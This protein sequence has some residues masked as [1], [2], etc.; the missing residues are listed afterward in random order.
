MDEKECREVCSTVI[1]SHC[2]GEKRSSECQSLRIGDTIIQKEEIGFK[3]SLSSAIESLQYLRIMTPAELAINARSLM[4][5][6]LDAK[7]KASEIYSID[8]LIFGNLDL[9]PDGIVFLNEGNLNMENLRFDVDRV[10]VRILRYLEISEGFDVQSQISGKKISISIIDETE[11]SFKSL[12]METDIS[13]FINIYIPHLFA[14]KLKTTYEDDSILVDVIGLM[15]L[16]GGY[17][18]FRSKTKSLTKPERFIDDIYSVVGSDR[19]ARFAGSRKE[20]I[21]KYLEKTKEIQESLDRKTGVFPSLMYHRL[22]YLTKIISSKT[23]QFNFGI[24][25]IA[26]WRIEEDD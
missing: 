26:I 1:L 5:N 12:E 15:K 7:E 21:G 13:P 24:Q 10:E 8:N 20:K 2:K 16:T 25:P 23:S 22:E 14:K 19:L 17:N 3:V 18:P 9:Y 4:Q 6:A 11:A